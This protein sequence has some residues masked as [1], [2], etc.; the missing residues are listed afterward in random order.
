MPS[1]LIPIK[2]S[3]NQ[4]AVGLNRSVVQ[5]EWDGVSPYAKIVRILCTVEEGTKN[6]MNQAVAGPNGVLNYLFFIN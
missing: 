6:H 4:F 3:P 5:C 1:F 2:G